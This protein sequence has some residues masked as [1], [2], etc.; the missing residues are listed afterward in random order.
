MQGFSGE[1]DEM[2]FTEICKQHS[3][4]MPTESY[5]TLNNPDERLLT[6]TLL[7]QKAN[8]LEVVRDKHTRAEE[9]LQVSESNYRRLFDS[10]LIGSVYLGFRRYFS[11]C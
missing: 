8:S 2:E 10:N 9:Q 4:V 1:M 3:R 7:Q 11:G 5:T 6:I